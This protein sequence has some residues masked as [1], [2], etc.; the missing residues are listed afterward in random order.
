MALLD[1]PIDGDGLWAKVPR[2]YRYAIAL[3]AVL[4]ASAG[5]APGQVAA[6]EDQIKAAYIFN[7]AKFVEW[8]SETFSS[9]AS[10]MNFCAFGR[11][12]VADEM[13]SLVSGK[14]INGRP[15]KVRHL[16]KL[17]EIKDCQLVFVATGNGRQLQQLLQAAKGT[18]VLVIGEALGFARSGGMIGFIT[19]NGKVLF[20][21]NPGS[22]EESRLK[23]SSKLLALA[24][25]VSSR[26]ERVGQ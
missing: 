3:L 10:P 23:I 11:S 4:A 19:E 17:E 16:G 18:P 1:H 15:T 20:E 24:R 6:T 2:L 13:D 8:P 14:N 22:A 7:F 21:V 26:T 9:A 12:Q 25:I 5:N